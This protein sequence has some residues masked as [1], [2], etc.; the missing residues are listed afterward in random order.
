LVFV[1]ESGFYLLPMVLRTCAPT[2]KTPVIRHYLT[3]DHLSVISGITPKGKLYMMVQKRA[4]KGPDVVN[5]LR[6]LLRHIPGKLLVLWDGA[7]IHRS[8]V[9]KAFLAEGAAAR[10]HLE[11]LPAYAP[12][13]NPD[14]GIWEYLKGVELKNLTCRDLSHLR[15]ELRKATKRLRHKTHIILGCIK[16]PGMV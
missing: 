10:I 1:D 6:H 15:Q 4:Y 9:I 7:P 12:E 5:F 2:G 8:K 13:L 3:R 11:P 14:E 16:Q